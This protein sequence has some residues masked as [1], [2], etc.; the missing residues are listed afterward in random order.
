VDIAVVGAGVSAALT[1]DALLPTGRT[2]AILDRRGP[3]KGSSP[4]S[5]ALL[6][7]EIDQPLTHLV[8]KIGRERAVRAYWRSATAVDCL[9][10]RIADLGLRCAFR[11]RHTAYL[12]GDVLGVNDLR[13]EAQERSQIGLRSRFIGR[14]ELR[15]R[16]TIEAPGA[17]WSNGSAELDPAALTTGLW[18]TAIARGAKIYAPADVVDVDVGRSF[19]TLT[20]ATG[21]AVRARHVVFATGYELVKLV[22][23]KNYSVSSTWAMATAPQP[24]RLWP[25]RC[26]IWQAADPYL[27]LRTTLDGRILAGGEDEE[28]SNEAKRDALIPRKIASIQRK[29]GKMFPNEPEFSWTGCFGSSTTGLPAIGEIPGAARCFAI[30]GYGGNGI[31]FS[32]IAAQLIQRAIL[33]LRDPD[34]DLF[35]PRK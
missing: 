22:K 11:A 33:G 24:K 34:A 30:L 9:R 28:F 17:I 19:V 32:M 21:H 14:D 20:T 5:T 16:T 6:Q 10:A 4:A 35:A 25:S 1:V 7:F 23:S 31:T 29:L 13:A 3:N 18:R 2:I 12:P 15:S 26:L 27:Y 8:Q